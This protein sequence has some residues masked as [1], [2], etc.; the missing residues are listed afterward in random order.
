[1]AP[2]VV[3]TAS[4]NTDN[5]V[6]ISW[7]GAPP[8]LPKLIFRS[9]SP[10]KNVSDLRRALLLGRVTGASVFTDTPP[11]GLAFF[12]AVVNEAGYFQDAPFDPADA[13]LEPVEV[14][15]PPKNNTQLFNEMPPVLSTSESSR[16]L[17]L[18]LK[19]TLIDPLTGETLSL[20][21]YAEKFQADLRPSV[22]QA[23]K[24]YSTPVPPQALPLPSILPPEDQKNLTGLDLQLATIVQTSFKKGEWSN[25][26][27]RLNALACLPLSEAT[28][29]RLQFYLA[30]TL[31]EQ[32][33]FRKATLALLSSEPGKVL[34]NLWLKALLER[35]EVNS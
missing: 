24:N 27:T 7:N 17:P 1:M 13:T 23:L 33:Q 14:P 11:A 34:K 21:R 12:Y 30:Q 28:G 3:T 9:G 22:R 2:L 26:E 4:L 8:P 15:L 20:D 19:E 29:S 16:P 18:P 35:L 25:C 32:G 31:A 5:T 6:R 10:I